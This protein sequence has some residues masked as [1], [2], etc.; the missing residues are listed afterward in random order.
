MIIGITGASGFLGQAL[1]AKTICRGHQAVV[2]KLPRTQEVMNLNVLVQILDQVNFDVI[3]HT[4]VVRQPRTALSNYVNTYL[5]SLLA[6]SLHLINKN[7]LFIHISSI[8]VV[9]SALQDKYSRSKR[10]A[11]QFL[12]LSG[13]TIIRPSLIW[14]WNGQGDA[15]RLARYLDKNLPFHFMFYPGN[16]YYPILVEDLAE[17]IVK[18][19]ELNFKDKVINVVGNVPC[20]LW[21]LASCLAERRNKK[22]LPLPLPPT[23]LTSFVPQIIQNIDYST[24]DCITC[25]PVDLTITIPFSMPCI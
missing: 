9:I 21:Q 8:N 25:K 23:Y 20:T 14:S 7:S 4:A 2:I 6:Q 12:T 19:T 24:F 13:V 15:G 3:I 10:S 16:T 18:I 5:P 17:L 1:L 11:E 22:L